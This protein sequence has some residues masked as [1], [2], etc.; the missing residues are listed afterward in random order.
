[1]DVAVWG[2]GGIVNIRNN[3][4]CINVSVLVVIMF[5]SFARCYYWETLGKGHQ[6]LYYFLIPAC[7]CTIISI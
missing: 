2:P 1:M 5:Y 7:E 3:L 6:H 4:D